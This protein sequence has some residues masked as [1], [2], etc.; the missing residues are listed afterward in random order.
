MSV[1]LVAAAAAAGLNSSGP[2]VIRHHPA[3]G[4]SA[5]LPL[6]GWQMSVHTL[7]DQELAMLDILTSSPYDPQK[8]LDVFTRRLTAREVRVERRQRGG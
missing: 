7:P 6:D 5:V 8:A 3:G 2:P 1:L 4:L